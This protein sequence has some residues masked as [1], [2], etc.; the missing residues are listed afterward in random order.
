MVK[1]SLTEQVS[2]VTLS[3]I[4][5]ESESEF[6]SAIF[7]AAAENGINIDMISKTAITTDR[8]NIG[9]TFSDN[10]MPKM[11]LILGRL[12]LVLPPLVSCGNTKV[13]I[14]SD[15]MIDAVGFAKKVFELLA[16]IKITPLMI[17]TSVDEISLVIRSDE[18]DITTKSLQRII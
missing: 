14:K 17:T 10:D 7:S 9:F 5:H 18:S 16:E 4:T 2:V 11:L 15:E 6:V 8:T 3:G 1:I 13:V 12:S